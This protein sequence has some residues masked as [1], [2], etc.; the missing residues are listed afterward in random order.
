MEQLSGL[1][2]AFLALDTPRSTG[3]VG[4]IHVVEATGPGG[5]VLTLEALTDLIAERIHLVPPMRRRVVEVPLGLG[6]PFWVEDP[7]FDLEFHVRE[8]ALP[9]PGS[10]QQLAEQVARIHARTL[11]RSRP[12]WEMYLIQGLEGDRSAIYGKIHHAMIDGVGGQEIA[13]ALLDLSPEGR[14]LPPAPPWHSEPVP[15]PLTLLA[16]TAASLRGVPMTTGRFAVD[17][18]RAAPVLLQLALPHFPGADLVT[19]AAGRLAEE[20]LG[21]RRGEALPGGLGIGDG[22]PLRHAAGRAPTTPFNRNVSPHRRIALR[23]VSLDVVRAIKSAAGLTVND[24]VMAAC[25]GALRRWLADH[26]ALPDEPLVAAVP[27][28]VRSSASEGAKSGD[29]TF[30]NRISVMLAALPTNEPDPLTRMRIAHRA[31]SAAKH[32]H[33]ALPATLLADAYQFTMPALVGL[34][35]RANA[36]LRVL[37]RAGLFNLF[38]SNVPGPSLPLYLAGHR[39]LASYPVSAL[40][41]GQGLNITV[42]SYLGGLHFGLTADRD[43]VPDVEVLAGYLAEEVEELARRTGVAGGHDGSADG[44]I[45]AATPDAPGTRR[46][47]AHA[48]ELSAAAPAETPAARTRAARA[49]VRRSG[50]VPTPPAR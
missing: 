14:P 31:T 12:L 5:S 7:D 21:S 47:L 9:A 42:L 32:Q 34:T 33:D 36:R 45:P 19:S 38:V 43:L 28:S 15:A 22:P 1:D 48:G 29:G 26:D 24:V 18:V 6:Q 16:R 17:V 2:A 49:A 37:E 30:G 35:M 39:L 11:D 25:A 13:A 20:A 23:S 44:R 8:L 27:V 10:V 46:R 41:D 50:P 40:A 4:G 3:H